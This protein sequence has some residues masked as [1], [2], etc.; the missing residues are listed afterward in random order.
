M[1]SNGNS[2]MQHLKG[3]GSRGTSTYIDEMLSKYT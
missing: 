3:K 2:I 1:E